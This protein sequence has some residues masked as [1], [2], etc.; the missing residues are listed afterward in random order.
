MYFVL[1]VR[2]H[3]PV[4]DARLETHLV[5]AREG[6][7]GAIRQLQVGAEADRR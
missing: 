2:V 1:H 7:E 6:E 3:A 4:V 5:P